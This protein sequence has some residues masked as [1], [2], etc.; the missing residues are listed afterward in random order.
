MRILKCYHC[1]K[2]KLTE[3]FDSDLELL[4]KCKGCNKMTKTN[5]IKEQIKIMFDMQLATNKH[6]D[7]TNWELHPYSF[8][9]GMEGVEAI[10]HIGWKWWKKEKMNLKQLQ[11]ELV[12]VWHFI[13][14]EYLV[15]C[16]DP[17]HIMNID[18]VEY[19]S[20]ILFNDKIYVFRDI[21]LLTKLRVFSAKALVGCHSLPLFLSILKDCEMTQQ[22][23]FKMYVGKN[24][25]N[26][27]RQDHG[28]KTGGYIKNWS[29][30]PDSPREDN[31]C[32]TEFM[33]VLNET[34]KHFPE[35]LYEMLNG[36][37]QTVLRSV[38]HQEECYV[39]RG[40]VI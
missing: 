12:D 28:Y 38:T 34:N 6:I 3:C 20:S 17:E 23:L 19:T 13:L 33:S 8:A 29:T 27:F 5:L 16:G 22:D 14:S 32:L 39:N 11:M 40:R 15:N 10:G 25:L 30:N 9:G 21:D 35:R 4:P 36:H 31:E 7:E 2:I 26:K 1:K 24:I 37:Y 18:L